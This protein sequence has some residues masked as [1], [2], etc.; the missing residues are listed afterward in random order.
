MGQKTV[1]VCDCCG[2]E[3]HGD[4][5]SHKGADLHEGCFRPALKAALDV[6]G[7]GV[8]ED[9]IK[10]MADRRADC[11]PTPDSN[12][13]SEGPRVLTRWCNSCGGVI[14][15]FKDHWAKVPDVLINKCKCSGTTP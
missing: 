14:V 2:K 8:F 13:Q 9:W 7:L 12:V 1:C 5:F 3:I 11:V 15:A 6:M 4:A 10:E